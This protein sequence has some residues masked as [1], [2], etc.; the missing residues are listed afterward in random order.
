MI[1]DDIRSSW[2]AFK[3]YCFCAVVIA[4]SAYAGFLYGNKHLDEQNAKIAKLEQSVE[5]LSADNER[6]TRR[7][8]VMNVETEVQLLT[9]QKS[10][11]TIEEG[12]AREADLK[13][14]I[15]FYKRIMA[16]ELKE[17][18]FLIE[19]FD[20][21]KAVSDNAY[22]FQLVLM[23]QDKI[24]SVVKG[25]LN[26]ELVGSKNGKPVRHQLKKLMSSDVKQLSFS[27]KYF[28]TVSGQLILP[29]DFIPEKVIVKA[30]VYQFQKKRGD[31]QR[32]FNWQVN[33]KIE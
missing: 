18:G 11:A 26:V 10:Q 16:P 27:F 21:E 6:L 22:R 3:F 32:E 20:V 25:N 9:S 24:K 23:Q 17:G 13:Q 12:L 14:E 8:N 28:Q 19:A 4:A 1:P 29:E 2:G 31:L 5:N 30:E 15:E 7:F 33:D